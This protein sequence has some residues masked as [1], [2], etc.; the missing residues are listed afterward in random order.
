MGAF[1]GMALM[2]FLRVTVEM[3]G[4]RI[5]DGIRLLE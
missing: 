2:W 3:L 4:L 5:P 1:L